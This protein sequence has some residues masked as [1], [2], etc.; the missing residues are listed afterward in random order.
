MV[1]HTLFSVSLILRPKRSWRCCLETLSSFFRKEL[2]TGHLLFSTRRQILGLVPYNFLEP[3][4]I[5]TMTSKPMQIEPLNEN[6]DIPAPPRRA[7]PSRPVGTE[8]LKTVNAKTNNTREFSGCIVKVH[9]QFTVASE[10]HMDNHMSHS[11]DVMPRKTLM[12]E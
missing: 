12:R 10:L 11:S 3:L 7:P 8:G 1:S 5:V 9:F 4:D 2:T 6:D